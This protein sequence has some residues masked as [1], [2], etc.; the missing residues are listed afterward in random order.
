MKNI[1]DVTHFKVCFLN[2]KK[3]Q[4]NRQLAILAG[5]SPTIF[6]V[7]VLDFCVRYGYRYFHFAIVTGSF[8]LERSF[9]QN[10]ITDFSVF[11][12]KGVFSLKS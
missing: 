12:V 2:E 11:L 8:V 7:K 4:K 10:R 1:P 5:A 6:A 9:S 3:A